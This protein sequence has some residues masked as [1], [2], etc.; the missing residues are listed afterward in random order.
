MGGRGSLGGTRSTYRGDSTSE[1]RQRQLFNS[2]N[3]NTSDSGGG[4]GSSKSNNKGTT[5]ADTGGIDSGG[6]NGSGGGGSV[7]DVKQPDTSTEDINQQ[8]IPP[9]EDLKDLFEQ[10]DIFD[11][12]ISKNLGDAQYKAQYPRY[13]NRWLKENGLEDPD[14]EPPAPAKPLDSFRRLPKVAETDEEIAIDV[15]RVNPHYN[16]PLFN[17]VAGPDERSRQNRRN[18]INCQRC[19]VAQEARNQG[20]DVEAVSVEEGFKPVSWNESANKFNTSDGADADDIASLFDKEDGSHPE[21]R[22]FNASGTKASKAAAIEAEVLSWGEGARGIFFVTW[23]QGRGA[24]VMNVRVKDGKALFTDSQISKTGDQLTTGLE[25]NWKI[26]F[27]HTSRHN[28]LL[29]VD[30]TEINAT[31]KTWMRERNNT[32]INLPSD[33]ELVAKTQEMTAQSKSLWQHLWQQLR[34]GEPPT[35]PPSWNTPEIRSEASKAL[36]WL[37]RPD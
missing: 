22:W 24:H 15:Q 3:S 28:G 17:L 19:V 14:A 20:Y 34:S 7:N 36:T 27:A 16:D 6:G 21:W 5:S 35:V 37:R 33:A 13:W 4:G 12:L 25:D 2:N 30:G 31:G 26:S 23:S 29:R 32:Q 9:D 10:S 18:R 11:E 8:E 1:F